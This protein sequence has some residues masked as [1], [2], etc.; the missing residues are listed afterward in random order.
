M[1]DNRK[2][3][4]LRRLTFGGRIRPCALLLAVSLALISMP[5]QA[6][7]GLKSGAASLSAGKYDAAVRQLSAA[8]NSSGTSIGQAA[9][10]LY[11]RG[12][13]YRK[14]GQ[15]GRAVSDLGAAI[16]LGL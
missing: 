2:R 16:W 7:D 13:A 12:V 10:A 14:L 11:L 5:A 3:F 4:L 1:A 8:I 9:K 15:P 6:Q